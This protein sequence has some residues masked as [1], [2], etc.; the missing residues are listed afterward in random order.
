MHSFLLVRDKNI[1]CNKF[2]ILPKYTRKCD[3]QADC[4]L[5]ED[6]S[7]KCALFFCHPGEYQCDSD[8]KSNSTC[9][10]PS[11]ICD[12]IRQCTD[13]SD[14]MNCETYGCFLDNQFQCDATLNTNVYCVP[15]SKR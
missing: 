10:Q 6:E 15:D 3:G 7:D 1:F 9:L 4:E 11:K 14:E 2:S 13:G 5:S 8:N 12:G